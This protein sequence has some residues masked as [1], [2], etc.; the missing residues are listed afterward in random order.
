MGTEIKEQCREEPIYNKDE[1]ILKTCSV[2]D[3]M[4]FYLSDKNRGVGFY[5]I[6][7]AKADNE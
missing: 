1:N 3:S 7:I 5:T 2:N 6:R 4:V